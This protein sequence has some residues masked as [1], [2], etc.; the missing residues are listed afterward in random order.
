MATVI[1]VRAR[2]GGRPGQ[3]IDLSLLDSIFSILGPD[4]AIHADAAR[5]PAHRGDRS[6]SPHNV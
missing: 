5:A 4:A 2:R 6:Q 1:A 3:V